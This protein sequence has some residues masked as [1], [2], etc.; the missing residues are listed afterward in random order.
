MTRT[1]QLLCDHYPELAAQWHPT[2]NLDAT[3]GTKANAPLTPSTAA[4]SSPIK[5]WWRCKHGHEWEESTNVRRGMPLWKEHVDDCPLCAIKDTTFS[6]SHKV[7]IYKRA[8][9]NQDTS[10]LLCPDCDKPGAKARARYHQEYDTNT[11]THKAAATTW[12][13]HNL[14]NGPT[15]MPASIYPAWRD[16]AQASLARTYA[17]STANNNKSLNAAQANLRKWR[18]HHQACL[19]ANN[20]LRPLYPFPISKLNRGRGIWAS[21]N[22]HGSQATPL[23][24]AWQAWA[25]NLLTDLNT[26]TI[27]TLQTLPATATTTDKTA[28]IT[29]AIETRLTTATDLTG[30]PVRQKTYRE[31]GLAVIPPG[32]TRL[33]R[34]DVALLRTRQLPPVIVEIDHIDKPGSRTKL[35]FI[36]QQGG[37]GIWIR[38]DDL[39]QSRTY[40][41][42]EEAGTDQ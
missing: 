40:L 20:S 35:D 37:I 30:R 9:Q 41:A 28:A 27:N 33:G 6:C 25:D 36:A 12:L 7:T 34:S 3:D 22:L 32:A 4:I 5:V 1:R 19:T 10:T 18:L 26:A 11:D 38:W 24:P 23:D 16:W 2:R 29:D 14:P 13:D 42:T 17:H 39:T 21:P 31:L 15:G 8:Y